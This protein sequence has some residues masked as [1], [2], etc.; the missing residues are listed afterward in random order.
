[1]AADFV[2]RLG[3]RASRP[4]EVRSTWDVEAYVAL[5]TG[6]DDAAA[7]LD[8][9]LRDERLGRLNPQ[10]L[11]ALLQA[12]ARP[13]TAELNQARLAAIAGIPA[14]TIAPYIDAAV[15]LGLIHLL[16]GSRA[17]V[18]KRAIGRPRVVFADPAIACHLAGESPARLSELSARS[19]LAP[20]LEGIVYAELI[21]QQSTSA[22]EYRIGHLRE[23]NGLEV[24][25]VIEL[26]DDTV[27][28]I[29]VRTAA[30]LRPHQFRGLAALA[31]RAGWRLRG[32]IVLNTAP[33]G[34]AYGADL[35][36]LPISSLWT[37]DQ[38]AVPVW[39]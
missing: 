16:P 21:R 28:G 2:A 6:A 30:S 37:W 4:G 29:E 38:T 3:S 1:M 24:D 27:Y 18:T 8:R 23:R 15:E 33:V 22:V 13:P 12:M 25:L 10:R 11:R 31:D 9:R 34:H 36:G 32:G 19:R 14:T 39:R 35:W 17:A 26:P 20:Y 7:E 5:L